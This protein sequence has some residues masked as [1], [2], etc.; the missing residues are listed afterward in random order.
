MEFNN[1]ELNF[2][3]AKCWSEDAKLAYKAF[4]S[5][6]IKSYLINESHYIVT[7][8]VCNNCSQQF[9]SVFTET[10]DWVDGEDPQYRIV[11][12]ITVEESHLLAQSVDSISDGKLASI[13]VGRRSLRHDYPKDGKVSIYWGS[14]I[15]IRLHD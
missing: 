8:R 5:L 3:C 7:I 11:I 14:G 13:G 6:R 15:Q 12:P 10:I 2:G 9:L 4:G 1:A